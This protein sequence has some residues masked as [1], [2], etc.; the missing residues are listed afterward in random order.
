[1]PTRQI[2]AFGGGQLFAER[3]RPV[4]IPY[5]LKQTGKDRPAIGYI[6]T[7]SGDSDRSTLAFYSGFSGHACDT[8]HLPLF[9]RTPDVRGYVMRQDIIFVGGG[10]TKS[11]LAVWREWGLSEVLR[12][13]WHEGIV[14]SGLSA[15]AICWFEQGTTDSWAGD[16]RAL[17]CL[18]LL[19]GSC[20]PHYDGEPDRRPTF[21]RMVGSG[22]I[23]PGIGIDDA[24]AAHFVDTELAQTISAKPESGVYRVEREHGRASETWLSVGSTGQGLS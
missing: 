19:P 11:M 16:L 12:E 14:L 6:G 23:K 24:A 15:G 7:A 10:N 21:Q 3:D 8:S 20:C 22:E 13:A 9:G 5:L 4:L 17:D 2:I 1:M 18:G